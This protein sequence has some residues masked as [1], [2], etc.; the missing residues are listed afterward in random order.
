MGDSITPLGNIVVFLVLP[1]FVLLR[2][3]ARRGMTSVGPAC[4]LCSLSQG[5]DVEECFLRPFA[6]AR[7][8]G[9]LTMAARL[10]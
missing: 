2:M 6:T 5:A 3:L 9:L 8:S 1:I 7:H 10:S 4:R